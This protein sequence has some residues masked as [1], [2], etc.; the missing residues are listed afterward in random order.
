MTNFGSVLEGK[1]GKLPHA[2]K[3]D[4]EIDRSEVDRFIDLDRWTEERKCQ[5]L[6]DL[7]GKALNNIKY[8][9]SHYLVEFAF[10][11]YSLSVNLSICLSVNMYTLIGSFPAHSKAVKALAHLSSS[12]STS[13]SASASMNGC[14]IASGSQDTSPHAS[15]WRV[16]FSPESGVSFDLT[17][18]PMYHD[19][20]VTACTFL[21]ADVGAFQKVSLCK[22]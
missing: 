13:A 22:C 1:V 9:V 8:I 19:N 5:K 6:L 11:P 17:A 10:F 12:S 18:G 4:G 2:R 20:W 16:S 21:P 7:F 3:K 14:E 15:R